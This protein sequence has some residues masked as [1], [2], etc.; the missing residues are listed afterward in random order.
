MFYVG[1]ISF[2]GAFLA[3]LLALI[4]TVIRL[5]KKDHA[6]NPTAVTLARV[7]FVLHTVAI[8]T[9]VLMQLTQD[10][11]NAYVVGVINPAMPNLLKAT[12]LWGGMAGSL[13]FWSWMVNLCLLLALG[14]K[15]KMMDGWSFLVVLVNLLFFASLSLF[16]E[17]PFSR[18][19]MTPDGN[20][21]D[22]V[23]RPAVGAELYGQ[24]DG[25][26]LNPL[27]RHFGMVI[28]PPLLYFGFGAFLIPFAVGI[29]QLARGESS[30]GLLGQTRTWLLAAWIFLTAGIVLGSWWSYD[31]LGWGGYWAWDPVETVS[32]LPWLSA[33]A[34]LH[35][36]LL[37]KQRHIFRRFN[38]A[39]VLLTYVL[40]VFGIL[41]TRAGLL[42]SVHAF[43]ESQISQPLTVFTIAL[44]VV[45]LGLL[46]WRWQRIGTG[47][48][49]KSYF[50][51]DAL[52]LYTNVLLL[53]ILAVCLWGLL[54]PLATG[55]ITGTQ[56]VL[57]RAYFDQTTAPLFIL[58][59]L[60]MAVCPLAGWTV[61]SLKKLG[62]TAYIPLA[63]AAALTV[64]SYFT[65][66]QSWVAL[67]VIFIVLAGLANIIF[68]TLRDAS[69]GGFFARWWDRRAR[70]GAY[71]VHA[72]ILLIA[73]G[74]MGMEALSYKIEGF[75]I[76]GDKMP[77]G[78][79]FAVEFVDITQEY[80]N[81]EYLTTQANLV[82]WRDDQPIGEL[83][84]G[85][86]LYSNRNQYVSV[87]D[88]HS[89]LRGDLY[90]LLLENDVQMGYVTIQAANNPLV[91]FMW[92]GTAMMI[93]GAALAATR[94]PMVII[95]DEGNA[96]VADDTPRDDNEPD[97]PAEPI[98][99]AQR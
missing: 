68:L 34:L 41:I 77:V 27:L 11:G 76:P 46:I 86:H 53:A 2:T 90:T 55:A 71:F 54:Y 36:L 30:E 42:S 37:Q 91:N 59:V 12:A 8:L 48:E 80:E 88:K 83:H 62:K 94:A 96:I 20:L 52:F 15:R 35:S 10:Y 24:L 51:R 43:G 13:F 45:S 22:G 89:S 23:F 72:G 79:R 28:H 9:L 81:P 60:L 33:T 78:E 19:W 75:M 38:L 69:R 7:S 85:Q 65:I 58:L 21:L 40:V 98:A 25:I 16:V 50:T 93:L 84:P 18:V 57:T 6:L 49:L 70:Y 47:W 64:L 73:L 3:A 29:S 1:V 95:T 87:P 44:F 74:I 32:L 99:E 31:V 67:T 39:L 82:L 63:I 56:Q 92:L 4:L 17:N 14:S 97:E 5:V 66:T 26:G 61:S